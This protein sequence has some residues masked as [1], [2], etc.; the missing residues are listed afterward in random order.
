MRPNK[1]G[2]ANRRPTSPLDA[3]WQFGCALHAP[4]FPVGGG[5]VTLVDKRR[6]EGHLLAFSFVV[7]AVN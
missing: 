5:R 4:A 3:R 1:M 6:S 2:R 7:E